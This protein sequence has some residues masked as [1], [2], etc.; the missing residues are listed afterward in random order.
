MAAS[1]SKHLLK[2]YDQRLNPSICKPYISPFRSALDLGLCDLQ[3]PPDTQFARSL[4]LNL[5]P[6]SLKILRDPIKANNDKLL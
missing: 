3:G 6:I 2:V 5:G 1:I 4:K